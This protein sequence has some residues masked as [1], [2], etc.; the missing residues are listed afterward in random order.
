M[1]ALTV[2][3]ILAKGSLNFSHLCPHA[4]NSLKGPSVSR[5]S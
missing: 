2:G 4:L 3:N 1:G 5:F